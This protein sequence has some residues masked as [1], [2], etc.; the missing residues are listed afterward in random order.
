MTEAY[1]LQWPPGR[2]RTKY[3]ERSRFDTTQD[4]AQYYLFDELRQLKAKDIILSTNIKLRRDGMPYAS[5]RDP[6]DRGIAVYF[7]HKNRDMV[8]SCDRWDRVKDNIQAVRH[9]IAAL[10]GIERWGSGDAMEAAFTGFLALPAPSERPWREVMDMGVNTGWE[11]IDTEIVTR[12]YRRLATD[13]HPDK[14]GGSNVLMAELNV[15]FTQAKLE[16][17]Q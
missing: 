7:K 6:D 11:I 17:S 1:P 9:T 2:P 12:Q 13:R 3:P 4:M 10:R 15:A 16:L 8:F 5:Q 14:V